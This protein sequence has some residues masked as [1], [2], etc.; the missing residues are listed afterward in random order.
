MFPIN[1]GLICSGFNQYMYLSENQIISSFLIWRLYHYINH[2]ASEILLVSVG[3]RQTSNII[4]KLRKVIQ[5]LIIWEFLQ[6][7][8]GFCFRIESNRKQNLNNVCRQTLNIRLL[9]CWSMSCKKPSGIPLIHT[10]TMTMRNTD[11]M[12]DSIQV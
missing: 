2:N 5:S 11:Y 7:N 1:N 12:Q 9:C 3:F 6:D 4:L 8:R 10:L